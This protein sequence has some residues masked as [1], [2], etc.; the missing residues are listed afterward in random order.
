MGIGSAINVLRAKATQLSAGETFNAAM[1]GAF[2]IMDYDDARKEGDSVPLALMKAGSSA[3][4]MNMLGFGG[5]LAFEAATSAPGMAYDF[6]KWQSRYRRQLGAEMK[7]QAFQQ[8]QFQDTQETYTMRQ[9]GMAIA[10]R[11]RYNTQQA[12]LG[13]EAM[14]MKK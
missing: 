9:A 12:M 10:S 13:N 1:T 11:S 8:A 5:Y 7:Q 3:V 14:Y 4:M 6:A 2:G